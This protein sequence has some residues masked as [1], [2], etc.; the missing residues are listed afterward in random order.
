MNVRRIS[1]DTKDS[2]VRTG[3]MG[4]EKTVE[5]PRNFI[6]TF[7][8]VN[9]QG[10]PVDPLLARSSSDYPEA[11]V[12]KQKQLLCGKPWT[13]NLHTRTERCRKKRVQ[14]W[15][16]TRFEEQELASRF[17]RPFC[18]PV[19]VGTGISARPINFNWWHEVCS[20]KLITPTTVTCFLTIEPRLA[21]QI[22]HKCPHGTKG[23]VPQRLA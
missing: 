7:L 23:S 22:A 3:T 4:P 11:E 20:R 14:L 5:A 16:A 12:T 1:P 15:R 8:D 17:W 9:L 21:D 2:A 6:A 13:I 18:E 19:I 10:E